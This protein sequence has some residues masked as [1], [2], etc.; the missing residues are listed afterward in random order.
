MFFSPEPERSDSDFSVLPALTA[1]SVC[2]DELNEPG[3]FFSRYLDTILESIWKND[4]LA[5]SQSIK[6]W[7]SDL[8]E[9]FLLAR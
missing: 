9:F 7:N 8:I 3:F 1:G 2:I 5:S 6:S 4:R